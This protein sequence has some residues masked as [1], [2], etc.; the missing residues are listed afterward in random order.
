MFGFLRQRGPSDPAAVRAHLASVALM[1]ERAVVGPEAE[2]VAIAFGVNQ[3]LAV[4]NAR[5]GVEAFER[6]DYDGRANACQRW[7]AFAQQVE[8]TDAFLGR[9][10]LLV[11]NWLAAIHWGFKPEAARLRSSIYTLSRR[12]MSAPNRPTITRRFD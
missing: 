11:A 10:A 2:A 4:L 1:G 3:A 7:M 12:P 9:G 6:Q 8:Q 5:G